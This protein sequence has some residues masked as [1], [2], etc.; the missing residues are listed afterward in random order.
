MPPLKGETGNATASAA[1]FCGG[2]Q[3]G[4]TQ[5]SGGNPWKAKAKRSLYHRAFFCLGFP[6][7]HREPLQ[8]EESGRA[9]GKSC[10]AFQCQRHRP[11]VHIP[12]SFAMRVHCS[13]T[14]PC[15]AEDCAA[16]PHHH[17]VQLLRHRVKNVLSRGCRRSSTSL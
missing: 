15:S 12:I 4:L 13:A 10:K 3:Q 2:G 1:V 5:E 17:C 11:L 14:R 16:R 6:E 7:S 8:N 9:I